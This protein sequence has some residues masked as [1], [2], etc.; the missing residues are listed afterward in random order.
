[1]AENFNIY[2]LTKLVIYKIIVQMNTLKKYMMLKFVANA[3]QLLHFSMC[4][5]T[6]WII[7]KI[8]YLAK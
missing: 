5:Q 4:K 7:V 8:L 2:H 3:L 6:F 1:M